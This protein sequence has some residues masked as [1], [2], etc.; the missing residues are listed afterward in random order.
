MVGIF[1][2]TLAKAV[3]EFSD[4]AI[5]RSTDCENTQRRRESDARVVSGLKGPLLKA[6]AWRLKL[7]PLGRMNRADGVPENASW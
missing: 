1:F 3:R 7:F 6:A 4:V 2:P 5:T